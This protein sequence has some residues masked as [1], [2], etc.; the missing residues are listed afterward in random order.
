[1]GKVFLA[2]RSAGTKAERWDR[3]PAW[4]LGGCVAGTHC[5]GRSRRG[6]G[7]RKAHSGR[8]LLS[9][10]AVWDSSAE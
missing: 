3:G 9:L 7:G 4:S 5:R 6:W 8:V 10:R 1:M 2:V